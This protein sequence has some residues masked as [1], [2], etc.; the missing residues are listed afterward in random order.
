[1]VCYKIWYA[2]SMFHVLLVCYKIWN[3]DS[4]FHVLL[5]CYTN[6]WNILSTYQIL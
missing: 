4:M 6:T 3:A 5:V 1:L 2:D